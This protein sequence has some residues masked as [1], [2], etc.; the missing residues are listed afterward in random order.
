MY[1][2]VTSVV[3]VNGNTSRPI[4]M[5]SSVRQGCLLSITLL[6]LCLNPLL[7]RLDQQ[8]Y[9]IRIQQSQRE[10]SNRGIRQ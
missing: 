4:P 8:L 5:H 6:A 3:Q 2:D 1:T 9:G 10:N 7:H